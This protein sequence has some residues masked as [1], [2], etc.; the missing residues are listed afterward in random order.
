MRPNSTYT[1]D[2]VYACLCT[3]VG[4][5]TAETLMSIYSVWPIQH[6]IFRHS[7]ITKCT[8]TDVYV[9]KHIYV[10]PHKDLKIALLTS[11]CYG[12]KTLPET[13]PDIEVWKPPR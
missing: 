8:S 10:T 12:T 13:F 7:A 3:S 11:V 1:E 6:L 9:W 2:C 4:W 5:E